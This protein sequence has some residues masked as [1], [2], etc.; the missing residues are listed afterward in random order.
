M[1]SRHH[2]GGSQF[3][4]IALRKAKIV[5]IFSECSRVKVNGKTNFFQY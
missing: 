5:Y 1:E 3:N 2:T 4:S